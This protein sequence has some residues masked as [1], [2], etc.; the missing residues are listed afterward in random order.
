MI[1]GETRQHSTTAEGRNRRPRRVP[2]DD[3]H[4]APGRRHRDRHPRRRA[5]HARKAPRY[6][7]DGA[8]MVHRDAPAWAPCRNVCRGREA[9]RGWQAVSEVAS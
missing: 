4:A 1:D 6:L 8:T 3:P 2:L 5:G 9:G 7:T